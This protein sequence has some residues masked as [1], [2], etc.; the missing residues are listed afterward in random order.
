[1]LYFTRELDRFSVLQVQVDKFCFYEVYTSK[2]AKDSLLDKM[3]I[4]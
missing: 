4:I 2:S 1:M 3:W